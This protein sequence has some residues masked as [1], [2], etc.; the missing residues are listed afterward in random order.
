M[1]KPVKKIK[2][3]KMIK[4]E[5]RSQI[6]K[7]RVTSVKVPQTVTVLVEW[8]KTHPL[9]KKT[10]KKSKK[11]LVHDDLKVSLGDVVEIVKVK[12]ISKNKHFKVVK[13]VGQEIKVIIAEQLKEEAAEAIAEVMPEKQDEEKK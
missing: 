7:G 10:F 13:V 8:Q 4:T 6:L 5:A 12:P 3:E 9:Y 1:I 2:T 11:Y